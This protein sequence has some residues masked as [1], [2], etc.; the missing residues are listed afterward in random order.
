MIKVNGEEVKVEHFPDN[1]QR[2]NFK[3]DLHPRMMMPDDR[4]IIDWRYES[5]EECMTLLYIVRHIRSAKDILRFP[6]AP[7]IELNM[8]YMPNARMDRTKA[9]DEIF[10]LKTFAE[11]I[12]FLD[13]DA[14]NV[15][16]PHSDV[17]PALIKNVIVWK[18]ERE[19]RN[20]LSKVYGEQIET[21]G[22]T[23]GGKQ[24][25][26]F[27]PDAG[28]MKRYSE[29]ITK[30]FEDYV[31]HM[32]EKP[33]MAIMYG[34]KIRN[35]KTG[36][37]ESLEILDGSGAKATSWDGVIIMIDDIIAYGGTFFYSANALS[38]MNP[39]GV[40]YAYATHTE[41]SVLDEKNSKMLT[42]LETGTVK[43]LFTTD[44]LYTGSHKDIEIVEGGH[45]S[46]FD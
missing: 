4:F 25:I 30:T 42:L 8:N 41:N 21:L 34:N 45:S 31:M 6:I 14:V 32:K 9:P 2:I 39:E 3:V 13:F 12:N 20:V 43:K 11:F 35:W 27:F 46:W 36:K 38:K 22:K 33:E 40:I 26:F 24:L 17:T 1:T 23:T 16:D 28:A 15:L 5:D 10:T 18:P 19:I 37:I 7:H 44:S 29:F